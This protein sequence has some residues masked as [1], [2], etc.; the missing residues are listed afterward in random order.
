MAEA[1][2]ASVLDSAVPLL[3]AKLDA[4]RSGNDAHMKVVF[5]EV[6]QILLSHKHATIVDI[7]VNN[8]LPHLAN[9]FAVGVDVVDV[10]SMLDDVCAVGW[11]W[12]QGGVPIC[13]VM[14]KGK[15]GEAA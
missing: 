6:K 4:C 9:R 5:S 14:P 3:R 12:E 10:H 7:D 1:W 15:L 2:V 11:D 8:V 13:F